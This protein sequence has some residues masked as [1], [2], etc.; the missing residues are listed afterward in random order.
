MPPGDRDAFLAE[1]CRDDPDL[2]ARVRELVRL[3]GDDGEEPLA[4]GAGLLQAAFTGGEAAEADSPAALVGTTVGPYRLTRVLGVG[5]MGAVY[6]AERTDGAFEREVAVKVLRAGLDA[7]G[8]LDRFRLERQIL[9]SLSHPA[10]AQMIDGGITEDGR[11]ALVMEYVEGVP[12]NR[13][14]D[15]HGLDVEAR[16]RLMLPVADAVEHAHRHFVVHR[17]IKP[18]NIL[19]TR[20]GAVKLLDFGTAKILE[21]PGSDAPV[22]ATRPEARFV[23]PEY[24]APE[25]LLGEAVSTQTDVYALG[26]LLYELLTG[27]RPYVRRGSETVLER[28]IRG[29]EPTAPSAA[30]LPGGDDTRARAGRRRMNSGLSAL[31]GMTPDALRRRLSGDIDAILLC[32]LQTRPESRYES[33]VAFREDLE[34]HLSGHP[35]AARGDS[36]AYRARR[37]VRRHR[38]LMIVIAGAFLI[39]T[40]SAIGLLLQRRAVLRQWNRAEAAAESASRQAETARQ[41]TSFLVDLFR[42]SDPLA[43]R[44]DTITVRSILERGRTRVDTALAD[45]PAVRAELLG[46]LA[47]VYGNLGSYDDAIALLERD[48]VLRRDSIPEQPGL[49]ASLLRLAHTEREAREFRTSV[50]PYR[51]AIEEATARGDDRSLAEARIGLAS[52][53]MFLERVDSAEVQLRLA[54]DQRAESGSAADSLYRDAQNNLA[55]LLRRRGDLAGADSLYVQLIAQQRR[56]PWMEPIGFA[57]ALNNLAIVRRMRG[58]LESSRE[59]YAEAYD[60]L[61]TILGPG[62]PTSLLVSGNMATV[63]HDLGRF[64]DAL[65]IYRERVAA[66]R[67][68]WPDGDWR[69]ADALMNL[70]GELIWDGH[71]ADAIKPLAEALDMAIAQLGSHHSWTN[72]YRGWLGA[73]AALS[74]HQPE[75]E[76]LFGWSLDGLSQYAGLANDNQVKGMLR[77]LV[78]VMEEKGLTEQAERYRALVDLSEPEPAAPGR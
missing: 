35:V 42:A 14:A 28:M 53:L 20:D 32:A 11:P 22:L 44:G 17:D 60:S 69:T 6:L 78:R 8:V 43:A 54:I 64:D 68:R 55:G 27:V 70:G 37:F 19:V 47:R 15:E 30:I 61:V 31:P 59:L 77:S 76:Q 10:I 3:T 73:A 48:V 67:E 71:A 58:D 38:T 46:A 52:S 1:T 39:A 74:D 4:P 50:G 12:I 51:D 9:A 16:I 45:Q 29:D 65:R 26:G 75:S 23:T 49:T 57:T 2:L 40:G 18:S 36:I 56:T 25:Q 72:V 24:A 41:V 34:R 13:F 7:Q 5:G 62:H 63:Y 66:A 21:A 33:V